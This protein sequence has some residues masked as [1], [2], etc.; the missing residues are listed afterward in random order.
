MSPEASDYTASSDKGGLSGLN[1]SFIKSL[2][3]KKKEGSASKKRPGPKPDSK[4]ARSRRQELNRQA[5]RTHRERKEAYVKALE[6]EVLRLKELYSNMSLDK[7]QL[8]EENKQLKEL[9]IQ[10]GISVPS[11]GS[12]GNII[13]EQSV[14]NALELT[15]ATTASSSQGAFTPP[16][17]SD[18]PSV[19]SA[20]PHQQQHSMTGG[21]LRTMTQQASNVRGEDLDQAG[22]DFVLTYDN[23]PSSRAYPSPPP[24]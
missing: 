15:T 12:I 17:P 5:Q 7:S 10:V 24:Q 2:T 16:M 6:D 14:G 22:I 13:T 23:S 9:L 11:R 20:H 4:P 21:Q 3:E 8:F 19:P 18:A 1:L